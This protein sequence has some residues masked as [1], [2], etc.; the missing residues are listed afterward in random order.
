MSDSDSIRLPDR[1]EIINLLPDN[2][3]I[4]NPVFLFT[5]LDIVYSRYLKTSN[6][7][8]F[9]LYKKIDNFL[10]T[11]KRSFL[12]NDEMYTLESIMEDFFEEEYLLNIKNYFRVKNEYVEYKKNRLQFDKFQQELRKMYLKQEQIKEEIVLLNKYQNEKEAK[13][14]LQRNIVEKEEKNSILSTVINRLNF[15]KA[16]DDEIKVFIDQLESIKE[17][18]IEGNLSNIKR[19]FDQKN[20]EKIVYSV[21]LDNTV[22]IKF[23]DYINII[24][25]FEIDYSKK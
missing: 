25:S 7:I 17:E 10:R 12:E 8:Y 18:F 23:L 4:S 11:K 1:T 14:I 5:I 3:D 13:V 16:V 9:C 15:L 22:R 6:E 19:K 21:R 24:N 2:T 20:V